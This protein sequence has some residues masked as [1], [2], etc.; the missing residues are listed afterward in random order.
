MSA[1]QSARWVPERSGLR[2]VSIVR[3]LVGLSVVPAFALTQDAAVDRLEGR[4]FC[5]D[6]SLATESTAL[7]E[8]LCIRPGVDGPALPQTDLGGLL[9]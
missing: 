7:R 6:Q 9:D 3:V 5:L 2:W 4:T 1:Y 8:M